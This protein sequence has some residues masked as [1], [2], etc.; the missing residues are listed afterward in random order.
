M[1][2]IKYTFNSKVLSEQVNI[3]VVLPT[4]CGA[5]ADKSLDE[6][7]QSGKKLRTLY[8][9]HGG[10]DDCTFYVRNTS[11]ERYACEGGFAAVLPEVKLSFYSDMRY[12]E[13]YFT[14]LS[15]ELPLVVQSLFPLSEKSEDHF[16]VGNSM[17]S[18]G[19]MKWAFRCPEFFN[20]AAGMSGVSG[21]EDL[22]FLDMMSCSEN[23]P[24]KNAFGTPEEFLQSE[25][26]L[27]YLAKKLVES[28]KRIPHLYSCC[29]TE[30]ELTY[31]GSKEFTTFAKEI[32]LPLTWD[33]G[34]GKHNWEFWDPWLKKIIQWMKIEVEK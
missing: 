10:S 5:H 24:V 6:I 32:G 1:A 2:L 34:P 3:A 22:G 23:T 19:A 8:V 27:K 26:D 9:L 13:K 11:I 28:G 20:A 31:K 16:V 21:L 29:G 18:H 17:G 12:G 14:Y 4:F 30:D 25:N 7:Y 15:E 33:K